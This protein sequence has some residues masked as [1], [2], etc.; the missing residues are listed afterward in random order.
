MP[1]LRW[2]AGA[3][4][5]GQRILHPAQRPPAS[6]LGPWA[7]RPVLPGQEIVPPPPDGASQIPDPLS[8]PPWAGANG[9]N[10]HSVAPAA[11]TTTG[12]GLE[13]ALHNPSRPA[14]L[15]F[16]SW[17]TRWSGCALLSVSDLDDPTRSGTDTNGPRVTPHKNGQDR[18]VGHT[19]PESRP[20]FHWLQQLDWF[21]PKPG[22]GWGCERAVPE[23][24]AS[25]WPDK[26]KEAGV[27]GEPDSSA[28]SSIADW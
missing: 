24:A 20:R 27:S 2:T 26:P 3:G 12:G 9:R 16:L 14:P 15:L 19:T 17:R 5:G 23:R 1:V 28:C 6:L 4:A 13:S 8:S 22:Y 7:Q 25:A 11:A 18:P 10:G 21:T